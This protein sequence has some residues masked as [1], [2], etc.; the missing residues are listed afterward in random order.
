MENK[1]SSYQDQATEKSGLTQ[2]NTVQTIKAIKIGSI[3]HDLSVSWQ[4]IY[5]QPTDNAALAAIL[6]AEL[7]DEEVETIWNGVLDQ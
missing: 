5:G 6:N 7:T 4:N 3:V 1:S 2:A